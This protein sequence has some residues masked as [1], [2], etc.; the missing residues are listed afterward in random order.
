MLT[1]LGNLALYL[2]EEDCFEEALR[3]LEKKIQLELSCR[4]VGGV[5]KILVD[6]AY[7]MERQN[8]QG[9]KRKQM[10]I[11]AY[12]LLDLMQENV[13]KGIVF[14]H[15]KAVYGEEIEVEESCCI[16]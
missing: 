7:T 11:Q 12:Y 3:Q 1:V 13:T 9:E 15:F 8:T 2:E 6:A 4:R 16:K 5:G 14:N 10:Y